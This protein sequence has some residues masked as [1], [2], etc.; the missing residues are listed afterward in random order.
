MKSFY[1]NDNSLCRSVRALL[2]DYTDN[3]LQARQAWEVE[4]H[5]AGCHECA[6]EVRELQATVHLLRSAPRHDT[7]DNFMAALHARLDT[8]DPDL[9]PADS[10]SV[11]VRGWFSTLGEQFY[12]T[13]MP[14][15]GMSLAAAALTLLFAV[16]RTKPPIVASAPPAVSSEGVHMSVE[17]SA[18]SPFS[19]PAADNLEFRAGGETAKRT[20]S[21]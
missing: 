17:A 15:L 14:V 11:R 1:N 19:D 20:R 3:T 13:R 16:N 21:F 7:A 18:S 10:L 5:L 12:G 2:S 4:K 9:A 8:V 6:A